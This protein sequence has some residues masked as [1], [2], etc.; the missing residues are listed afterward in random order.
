MTQ[1]R[2]VIGRDGEAVTGR[3][4]GDRAQY[5]KL[6]RCRDDSLGDDVQ[7]RQEAILG[8]AEEVPAQGEA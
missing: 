8:N 6:A 7:E 3:V 4:L 5:E 1:K 2:T